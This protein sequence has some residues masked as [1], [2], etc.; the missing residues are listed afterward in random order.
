M[1]PKVDI[2]TSKLASSKG[3]ASASASWNCTAGLGLGAF[4]ALVEQALHVVGRGDDRVA[5][6]R[7]QRGVAVA[8]GHVEHGLVGAHVGGLG[9]CLADDLQGGA[10]D[11]VVAAGPG[12]LLAQLDGGEVGGAGVAGVVAFSAT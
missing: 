12:G 3:S 11:G 4:A 10:D 8:G 1:T 2:T 9:Q 6:C 5:A 7:G